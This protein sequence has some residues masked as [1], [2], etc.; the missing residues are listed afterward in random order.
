MGTFII[1]QVYPSNEEGFV[2]ADVQIN[3]EEE[4]RKLILPENSDEA[5][6]KME[7]YLANEDA[8]EPVV[9]GSITELVDTQVEV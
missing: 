5:R 9:E 3:D 8:S 1:K 6:A 2:Y 4:V 7:E